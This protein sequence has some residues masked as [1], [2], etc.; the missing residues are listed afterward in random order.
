M[1]QSAV[2]LGQQKIDAIG[3]DF[4]DRVAKGGL[5]T[6]PFCG[7]AQL[8]IVAQLLR[9]AELVAQLI[10]AVWN[11]WP[12]LPRVPRT[13]QEERVRKTLTRPAQTHHA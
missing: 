6:H 11:L 10:A 12:R 13:A 2:L 5:G 9:N 4:A 1:S 8:A 3:N 7:E